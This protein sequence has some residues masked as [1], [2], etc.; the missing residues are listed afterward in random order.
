MTETVKRIL[1][2]MLSDTQWRSLKNKVIR[3]LSRVWCR[4]LVAL[5]I[6]HKTDK[7]DGHWYAR[8]YQRHFAPLR[9]KKLKI[10]EIGVG[11][12]DDPLQGG[13]SLRMWKYYFPKGTIYSCDIYD[14][15]ALQEDRIIIFQGSQSDRS[16][17]EKMIARTGP[18]DIIIDD[19]SHINSDVI[20][21]FHMLFPSLASG[22]IYV[23]ED[24]QTSYWSPYGGDSIN[25]ENPSTIMNHFKALVH[26]L[27]YQ[28]FDRPGYT[29]SFTDKNIIS[30]HFYHNLIFIYKGENSE[31]SNVVRDNVLESEAPGSSPYEGS[32]TKPIRAEGE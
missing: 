5:A 19:G 8:H 6:I 11:G 27:N 1:K 31:G 20:D 21:T 30:L 29:P 9:R 7:W 12:Y 10:L 28:E 32:H 14:K 2:P 26:G 22:G 23:I 16:F 18:L 24:T 25:L 13:S 3:L 15:S 4:D 17:L